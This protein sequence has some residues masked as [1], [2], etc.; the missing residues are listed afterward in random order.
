[1]KVVYMTRA[2]YSKSSEIIKDF[3]LTKSVS[4]LVVLCGKIVL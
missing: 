3:W 4:K 1:M 2:L